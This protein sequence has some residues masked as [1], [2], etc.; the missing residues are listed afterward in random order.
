MPRLEAR[1][2]LS[3]VPESSAVASKHAMK[4]VANTTRDRRSGVCRNSRSTLQR[5]VGERPPRTYVYISSS[6]AATSLLNVSSSPRY[7]S[8][9]LVRSGSGNSPRRYLMNRG[10][11]SALCGMVCDMESSLVAS[12]SLLWTLCRAASGLVAGFQRPG[13]PK[14]GESLFSSLLLPS[15]DSF[16][17]TGCDG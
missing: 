5:C 1:A 3:Q 6:S 13:S 14:S 9:N 11:R 17:I 15:L 7:S 2:R 4:A 12:F 10:S 8:S 16:V